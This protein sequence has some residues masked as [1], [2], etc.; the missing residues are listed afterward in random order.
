MHCRTEATI[1]RIENSLIYVSRKRIPAPSE[2]AAIADIVSVSQ[3]RNATLGVTGTLVSTRGYFAQI[4]EGLPEAIEELMDS[5]RRDVRH[6]HVT[7]LR[8]GAIARRSFPDWSMAYSGASNYL[9][10]HIAP[11][12]AADI[13][14]DDSRIDRLIGFMSGLTK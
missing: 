13:G 10:R 3:A 8:V 9:T 5:I 2:E 4:L 6:D 12:L 7:V 1:S 11:L 14:E